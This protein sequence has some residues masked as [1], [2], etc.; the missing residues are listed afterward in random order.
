MIKILLK[1]PSG[2][3]VLVGDPLHPQLVSKLNSIGLTAVCVAASRRFLKSV[4][5]LLTK[6]RYS[7]NEYEARL[8]RAQGNKKNKGC[9]Q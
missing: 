5:Y 2:I 1:Q 4:K 8:Q 7:V 6:S 9:K 3:N